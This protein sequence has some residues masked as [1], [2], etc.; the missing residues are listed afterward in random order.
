MVTLYLAAS[1]EQGLR[2]WT[3]LGG[4]PDYLILA[5]GGLCLFAGR[6]A[7]AIIGFFDGLL[8]GAL[9]GANLWQIVLT[10]TVAGFL[11]AWVAD[12]GIERNVFSAFLMGVS[13][14]VVCRIGLMFLAP[15]P[16]ILPFVGDT[17]RTAVFNGILAM[18]LYTAL[19]RFLGPRRS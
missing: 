12:S 13:A 10:R 1:M 14:V 17:I 9:A 7:G 16:T 11:I 3:L 15:P 19:N 5:L 18:L 8:Y 4:G 2:S 6:A